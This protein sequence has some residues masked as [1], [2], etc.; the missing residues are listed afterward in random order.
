MRNQ[1]ELWNDQG[2]E[3]AKGIGVAEEIGDADQQVAKQG[4]DLTRF[5]SQPLD[6]IFE[7]YCL[8]HLHA[9]LHPALKG[10]V[11]VGTE[12]VVRFP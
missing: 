2:P 8:H 6:V 10:G 12:I 5:L 1:E 7:A 11:L 3:S 4:A 9:A